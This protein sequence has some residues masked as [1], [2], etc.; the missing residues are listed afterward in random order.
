M[1]RSWT[2]RDRWDQGGWLP[3]TLGKR[4]TTTL[5]RRFNVCS[6]ADDVCSAAE[7]LLSRVDQAL[8]RANHVCIPADNV[9]IARIKLCPLQKRFANVPRKLAK[10]RTTSE[11]LRNTFCRLESK[12]WLVPIKLATRGSRWVRRKGSL[13]FSHERLRSARFTCGTEVPEWRS[14]GTWNTASK[15][16]RPTPTNALALKRRNSHPGRR[17]PRCDI[18]RSCSRSC[19]KPSSHRIPIPR[20]HRRTC[21]CLSL[22][23]RGSPCYRRSRRALLRRRFWQPVRIS[24]LAGGLPARRGRR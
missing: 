10:L 14:A 15:R 17:I 5:P 3:V 6:R 20:S 1:A 23:E 12:S 4:P 13:R 8:S 16:C 24:E 21:R 7:H 9:C 18:P 2:T 22:Q 11:I 19:W